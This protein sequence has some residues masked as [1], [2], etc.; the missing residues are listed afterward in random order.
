MKRLTIMIFCLIIYMVYL[1]IEQIS[2]K[3]TQK[4]IPLRICVTGTRGKSGVVRLIATVLRESG[5]KTLAKVTGSK[6]A[7]ILPDGRET[8][9][10]RFGPA[11]ILEQIK[12]LKLARKH[13]V[14]AVV[15][16]VMSIN[17][18]N[19]YIESCRIINPHIVAITNIRLDHTVKM[20][21]CRDEIAATIGLTIPRSSMV[22]VNEDDY[23]GYFKSIADEKQATAVAV[24]K[25][26]DE[27]LKVNLKSKEYEFIENI[28]LALAMADFL[29]IDQKRSL[30]A[31]SKTK[32]D[33]GSL[34]VW[35]LQDEISSNKLTVISAF[36]ANDPESTKKVFEKCKVEFKYEENNVIGVLNLRSDR[37]E[38][39]V[40]WCDTLLNDTSL[41]LQKI[42][43]IGDKFTCRYMQRKLRRNPKLDVGIIN[44]AKPE[45]IMDAV[46]K[47]GA[48]YSVVFGFGNIIGVAEKLVNYWDCCGREIR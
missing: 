47:N 41:K 37:P 42:L 31:L 3:R 8:E 35:K 27:E 9:I 7:V 19:H 36:A 32:P 4:Q 2:I 11:N 16:E 1:V 30:E 22:F 26:N 20:G 38:R 10:R 39:T 6:P 5:V 21:A 34:R 33:F 44:E 12:I 14:D 18:E 15:M 28:E 25:I 43:L 46:F 24:P 29:G 48:G 45:R 40:Q 17:P 13:Q 23:V